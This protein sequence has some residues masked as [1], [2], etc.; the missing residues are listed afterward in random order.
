[1][2]FSLGFRVF[3]GFLII[4]L[5]YI[6]ILIIAISRLGDIGR[7]ATIFSDV[8]LPLYKY[9]QRLESSR[10]LKF[11]ELKK[12]IELKD[13]DEKINAI[14]AY[15]SSFTNTNNELIVRIKGLLSMSEKA[16]FLSDEEK[17]YLQLLD[18]IKS[19][20]QKS[21]QYNKAVEKLIESIRLGIYPGPIDYWVPVENTENILR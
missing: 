18:R 2:K 13:K 21:E 19:L 12:N 10:Y 3:I 1:M 16:F 5:L 20:E 15:Y 9:V 6:T 17:S 4:N 11:E 7:K 14:E 8:Y